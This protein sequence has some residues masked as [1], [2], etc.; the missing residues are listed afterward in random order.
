MKK[1]FIIIFSI[2]L[3]VTFI[4][5]IKS[6]LN[7]ETSLLLLEEQEKI[8]ILSKEEKDNILNQTS[9]TTPLKN[10]LSDKQKES[11]L[12]KTSTTTPTREMTYEERMKILNATQ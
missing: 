8:N 3:L 5:G 7:K 9:T 2:L 12:N 6:F 1:I 11:I 10:T 4:F